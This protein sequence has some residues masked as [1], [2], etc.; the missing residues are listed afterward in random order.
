MSLVGLLGPAFNR[1]AAAIDTAQQICRRT[2]TF[3]LEN[4]NVFSRLT[5]FVQFTSAAGPVH[6]RWRSGLP[7]GRQQLCVEWET[8]TRRVDQWRSGQNCSPGEKCRWGSHLSL[9]RTFLVVRLSVCARFA[10]M[11]GGRVPASLVRNRKRA[12]CLS[13]TAV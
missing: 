4:A 13:A 5:L 12:D 1:W 9:C 2:C 11:R 6:N 8:H 10:P 7:G 3:D